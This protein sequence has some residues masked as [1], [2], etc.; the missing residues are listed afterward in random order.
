MIDCSSILFYI[1]TKTQNILTMHLGVNISNALQQLESVKA[2][3]DQ[4][5]DPKLKVNF[6]RNLCYMI[7]FGTVYQY[8]IYYSYV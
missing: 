1:G 7:F 2:A 3:V 8:F 5:D 4:S 6:L